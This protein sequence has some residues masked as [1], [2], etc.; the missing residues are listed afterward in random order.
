MEKM[1]LFSYL[2]LVALLSMTACAHKN[3]SCCSKEKESCSKEK[4]CSDGSCDKESKKIE[5]AP[6]KP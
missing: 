3:K 6:K 4:K 1:K 5:A 2:I